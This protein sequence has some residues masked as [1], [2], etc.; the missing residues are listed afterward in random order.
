[1]T[2]NIIALQN[3]KHS[4][5]IIACLTLFGACLTPSMFWFTIC[6]QNPKNVFSEGRWFVRCLMRAG[7]EFLVI[8]LKLLPTG[9][10]DIQ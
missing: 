8:M 6:L 2:S 1:M 3:S 5:P 9:S 4:W 10:D 7:N